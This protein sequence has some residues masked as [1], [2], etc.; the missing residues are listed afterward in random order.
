M[1]NFQDPSLELRGSL[2]G[3]M[4][5]PQHPSNIGSNIFN[6]EGILTFRPDGL[7]D[8][9]VCVGT[10]AWFY[11]VRSSIHYSNQSLQLN[12]AEHGKLYSGPTGPDKQ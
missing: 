6:A 9:I 4:S 11:S 3:D 12:I 8:P 1:S 10:E 2:F 7:N 5:N